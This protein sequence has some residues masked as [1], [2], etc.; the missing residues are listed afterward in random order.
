MF[1]SSRPNMWVYVLDCLSC[2]LFPHFILA[3]WFQLQSWKNKQQCLQAR[4]QSCLCFFQLL[5][6]Y[7]W[8]TYCVAERTR[9][10]SSLDYGISVSL[11]QT[12]W[13]GNFPISA[14]QLFHH[15]KWAC[16]NLLAFSLTLA[17]IIKLCK[18]RL[19]KNLLITLYEQIHVSLFF[20]AF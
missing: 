4:K 16:L 13:L 15:Y 19:R 20:F 10:F 2:P 8:R 17:Y 18:L 3:K 5:F 12:G 7:K 6:L 11:L 14:K 1:R 9:K